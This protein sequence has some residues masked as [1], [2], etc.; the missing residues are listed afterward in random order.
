M[1]L[2]TLIDLVFDGAVI[3]AVI[4]FIIFMINRHDSKKDEVKSLK[5]TLEEIKEQ[6]KNEKKELD[7]RFVV[8]EKDIVRTQLLLLMSNYDSEDEHELMQVAEHYFVKLKADWYMTTL[9]NR[10]LKKHKIS[11]PEWLNKIK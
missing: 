7:T 6:S 2:T 5:E 10:F 11:N 9:F 1:T 8:L 4:S 3:A